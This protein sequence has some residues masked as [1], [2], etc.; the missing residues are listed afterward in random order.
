MNAPART[1][2]LSLDE[3]RPL[4]DWP[5]DR[6][7]DFVADA[8]SFRRVWGKKAFDLG[9]DAV[10]LFGVSKTHPFALRAWG[11]IPSVNGANVVD[12]QVAVIWVETG[13]DRICPNTGEV[14][15]NR[16]RIPKR[17]LPFESIPAWE[18]IAKIF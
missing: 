14:T 12:V 5:A 3:T 13:H 18:V 2:V 6:W 16:L 8:I 1:G 15:P 11:A 10:D 17:R 9:W 7:A 4:P